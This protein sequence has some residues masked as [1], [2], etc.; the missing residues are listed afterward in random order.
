[1]RPWWATCASAFCGVTLV[2]LIARDLLVPEVRDTEVWFGLEVHGRLAWL[3]APFHWLLFATGAWAFWTVQPRIWPWAPLYAFYV[4]GS[5]LV[6]N[7]TSAS[8]G[9]WSAGLWQAAALCVPAV[10]LLWARP[11]RRPR[12]EPP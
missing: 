7:L 9:G 6:W 2:F 12:M 8:G 4:A 3:S 1:M 5:H 10:A 11:R